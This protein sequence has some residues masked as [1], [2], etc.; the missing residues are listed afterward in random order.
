MAIR[1]QNLRIDR[2]FPR[3]KKLPSACADIASALGFPDDAALDDDVLDA[4]AGLWLA[5]AFVR[6]EALVLGDRGS[7]GYLAPLVSA[8]ASG[9]LRGDP[10]VSNCVERGRGERSVTHVGH[11]LSGGRN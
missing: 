4:Y 10:A 6:G 2:P 7:G 11:A 3:Y 9:T 8:R 5:S 1:W